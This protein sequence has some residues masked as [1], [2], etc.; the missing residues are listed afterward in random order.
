M[1]FEE[2]PRGRSSVMEVTASGRISS[3]RGERGTGLAEASRLN[4]PVVLS[5]SEPMIWGRA[6]AYTV[7]KRNSSERAPEDFMAARSDKVLN[8]YQVQ[9]KRS[10]QE[11]V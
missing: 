2:G 3:D 4:V 1:I 6:A 7:G 11:T 8:V 9:R 5:S 10:M